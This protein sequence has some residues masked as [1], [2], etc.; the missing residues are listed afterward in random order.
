MASFSPDTDFF[1]T[2]H[3]LQGKWKIL[4]MYAGIARTGKA[5]IR[6]KKQPVQRICTVG[7]YEFSNQQDSTIGQL[8]PIDANRDKV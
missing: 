1:T 8:G 4:I 2:C 5:A 7:N 6:Q 3:I